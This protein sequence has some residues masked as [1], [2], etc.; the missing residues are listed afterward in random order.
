LEERLRSLGSA[1]LAFSG[2]VDSGVLAAVA[3][4]ALGAEKILA[5]TAVSLI[6]PR[7]EVRAAIALAAELGLRHL[8]VPTRELEREEFCLNP[9]E[10]CYYCKR[11]L[12]SRL[13]ELAKARGLATVVDGANA[14]DEGDFR[15]GMQAAR[16]LGVDSPLKEVGLRKEEIRQLAR[17]MGLSVWN[18]PGAACLASRFP[19]GER[20]TRD[21]L[22]MVEEAEAFLAT[23]G[24]T[25][26]R[27]RHH[28]EVARIEVPADE[29]GLALEKRGEISRRLKQIGYAYAALDLE[30]YRS[31]SLNETLSDREVR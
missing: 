6:H 31:G 17:Q 28:R 9:P 30:G 11:E 15:P 24:F 10:R 21:K 18:K 16:E 23:L 20:I 29:M 5:V 12:Y 27:V 13:S 26:L 19:Y 7:R 3:K 4:Q 8:L 2:G 14:D 22:A 1:V 25:Q